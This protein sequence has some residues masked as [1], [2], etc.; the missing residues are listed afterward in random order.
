MTTK[1]I[2][3]DLILN[4]FAAY[5]EVLNFYTFLYAAKIVTTLYKVSL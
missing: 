5:T 1:L 2:S 3:E 4:I